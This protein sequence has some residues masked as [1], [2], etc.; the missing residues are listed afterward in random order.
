MADTSR[1]GLNVSELERNYPDVRQ[2][3]AKQPKVGLELTSQSLKQFQAF[4]K[5]YDL[6]GFKVGFQ[7][8][9]F[10]EPTGE[11]A[12]ALIEWFGVTP[13]STKQTVV[14]LLA[15][16]YHTMRMNI[17]A[18]IRF[19]TSVMYAGKF[20]EKRVVR[21]K[22]G[23]IGTL[24]TAHKTTRPDTV[25][26]LY[27]NQLGLTSVPDVVYRFPN[28]AELDLS[29]NNLKT[30][31]ARLTKDL[32]KLERLSFLY[33]ALTNDSVFFMPNKHLKALN[34]QGNQLTSLPAGVRRNRRLESLW[35]GN[36]RLKT[37]DFRGL[38][39]LT[40]LNIYNAELTACPPSVAKLRRLKVLDLYY[41]NLTKL[42]ASL[43]RLR[44]LEQLAVSH[45]K[46]KQL[47]EQLSQLRRLQV[48]YAHHNEIGT[49]PA[50]FDRYRS[51]RL[52]DLGYNFF[53]TTPPV[54]D[55]L[56][57]LEE[58]DLNNNNL[59]ELSPGLLNLSNL[60]KLYLRNNPITAGQGRMGSFT[61]TI[62]QLEA[63]K[64]E[65]FH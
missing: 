1:Y 34:I 55:R 41:N 15:D 47:P 16:Y 20:V 57:T 9:E 53:S 2:L 63:R 25:K 45:N 59:Q 43:G 3:F 23:A 12:Y 60:K 14:K 11:A 10:F 54:L 40:D 17:T 38:R 35:L 4:Y 8:T 13:D 48:L 58:L 27:F 31:P 24:E 62:Q 33:N 30:L 61:Q 51:L 29:K 18:N 65:V 42:P 49:L 56:Y 6:S 36:N 21:S 19:R 28:L 22:P 26:I 46:L 50:R 44:R 37:A 7:L 52:L 39:R 32:P 5:Q 64:T